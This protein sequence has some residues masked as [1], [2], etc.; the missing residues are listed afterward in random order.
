MRHLSHFTTKTSKDQQLK[1]CSKEARQRESKTPPSKPFRKTKPIPSPEK[2]PLT[3]PKRKISVDSCIIWQV[4]VLSLLVTLNHL[5]NTP[6]LF[7]FH[8]IQSVKSLTDQ[9]PLRNLTEYSSAI[10]GNVHKTKL[11]TTLSESNC[12]SYNC[13]FDYKTNNECDS[14]LPT[15]YD[16]P[17]PPCCTHILRDM[18]R[19]FDDHMCSLGLDYAVDFGTL[20]G[21]RRN[22]SIIPWTL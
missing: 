19:I 5:S 17:K 9:C 21:F 13:T 2:T 22:D 8:G 4:V 11:S 7:Q 16:G 6:Q 18:S 10:I 3:R 12:L 14:G 20:L 1:M 15:N